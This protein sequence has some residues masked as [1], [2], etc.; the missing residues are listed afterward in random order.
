MFERD[1]VDPDKIGIGDA[2]R[3][4]T[5]YLGFPSYC[6]AGKTMGLAAYGNKARFEDIRLFSLRNGHIT[7]DIPNNYFNC[8]ESLE[9][10]LKEKLKSDFIP[11]RKPIEDITQDHADLACLIQ[12]ETERILAEKVR[13]LINRTGIKNLC[14]AG[15]IGLNT[16]ANSYIKDNCGI[17]GIYIVP[18]AGDSGQCLG[19]AIY[20]YCQDNGYER[21]L[22]INY[23]YLGRD[24]SESEIERAIQPLREKNEYEFYKFESEIMLAEK[25]ADELSLGRYIGNYNGRSEF[26]PRALGNRSILA[27]PMLKNAKDDLNEKIKYREYFRPFAPIV[28][29]DSA[30][31]YFK[32]NEES[33]YMLLVSEVKEKSIIPAVTHRDGTARVQTMTAKQNERIFNILNA[34][35]KRTGV[36]VILNTSF[37]VN[38]KPIVETP[39]DAIDCFV[40]TNLDDLAIGQYLIV[41]KDEGRKYIKADS[42]SLFTISLGKKL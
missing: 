2:Y 24:Y 11:S 33:P 22:D 12:R 21:H 13:Y 23:S 37:N 40:N 20:A 15:G 38:G 26:G 25:I 19:N 42:F 7:C 35:E 39:Q 17:E 3:Y 9:T 6:Y 8:T 32:L 27:N 1:L 36:P 30:N 18:A 4:F 5:H 41:K 16:V 28:R 10:Y 14:I 31:E 29:Y 34:F